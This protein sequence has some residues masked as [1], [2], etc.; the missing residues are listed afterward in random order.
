MVSKPFQRKMHHLIF[1]ILLVIF[2]GGCIG[3]QQQSTST[4]EPTT[5][6]QHPETFE[7]KITLLTCHWTPKVGEYGAKSDCVQIISKGAAQGPV[8]ARLELPFLAWSTDG[9]DCGV[10]GH[11]TGALVGAGHTCVRGEGQPE[12]TNWTVNTGGDDCPLKDYFKN[13]ISH[14]VKLYRRD[15]VTPEKVAAQHTVC[16]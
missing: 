8:G 6:P 4:T 16:Q 10:W 7:V 1:L 13:D 9:F 5:L 2:F 11:E 12:K 14:T 3:S 15:A